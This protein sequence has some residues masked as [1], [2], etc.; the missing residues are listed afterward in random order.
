MRTVGIREL[1][2]HLSGILR[3]V[4]AGETV[5]VTDRGRVI[6]RLSSP[7][8]QETGMTAVELGLARL[9]SA[10]ALRVAESPPPP[11]GASPVRSAPGTAR[12]LLDEG[13]DES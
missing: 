2:A 6:A 9:K 8:L 7:A 5:L 3:D 13:R 1:K 11:Y 4:Q 10:G 12:I